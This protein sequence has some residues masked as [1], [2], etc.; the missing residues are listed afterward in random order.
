M[1]TENTDG[2]CVQALRD[3]SKMAKKSD[4]ATKVASIH[5]STYKK[6]SQ[7]IKNAKTS[8]M[9]KDKKRGFKKYRGQG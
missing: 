1:L 9:N 3:E 6:T 8:S 7:T 2:C 5:V 4:T